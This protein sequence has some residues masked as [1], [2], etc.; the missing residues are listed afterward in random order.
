M[1]SD[2]PNTLLLTYRVQYTRE[3]G[4]VIESVAKFLAVQMYQ[5]L[6]KISGILRFPMSKFRYTGFHIYQVLFGHAQ[7]KL[8]IIFI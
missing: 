1:I 7:R 6:I 2:I 4:T 8:K 3:T 5:S